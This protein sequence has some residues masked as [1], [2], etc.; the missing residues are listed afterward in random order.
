MLTVPNVLQIG[1]NKGKKQV[2]TDL[3]AIQVSEE[4]RLTNFSTFLLIP[5]MCLFVLFISI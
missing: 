5:N 3:D 1:K 4:L 2:T